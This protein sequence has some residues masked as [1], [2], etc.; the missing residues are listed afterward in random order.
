MSSEEFT[1]ADSDEGMIVDAAKI[2]H[3]TKPLHL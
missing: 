2:T 3:D 1:D